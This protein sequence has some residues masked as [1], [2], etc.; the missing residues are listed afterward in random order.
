MNEFVTGISSFGILLTLAAFQAGAWLR[1]KTGSA[2]CNPTLI[3]GAIVIAVLFFGK[4]DYAAYSNGARSI[5][6]LLTPTTVCLAVP[7]YRQLDV[8]KRNFAAIATGI[9]AGI[10]ASM[11][12]IFALCRVFSLSHTEYITLLP[13][14]ITT[15]I[16]MSLAEEYGG[17]PAITVIAIALTGITG[18][19]VSEK[20]CALMHIKNPVSVGIAFGASSHAMG[21]SRAFEIGE[22]EGAISSLALA[23]CGI[24]TAIIMP[25][26]VNWM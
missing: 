26:F 1:R 6:Y 16:G 10:L 3:G 15:A 8:L 13:K 19:I 9:L 21:T 12:S 20:I 24:L 11:L 25:F 14:S 18:G 7:L 4:I 17:F 5:S 22:V 23:V 2:L